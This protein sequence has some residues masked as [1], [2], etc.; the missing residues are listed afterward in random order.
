MLHVRYCTEKTWAQE[1]QGSQV[2]QLGFVENDKVTVNAY[3]S[4]QILG[5]F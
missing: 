1:T 3:A 5:I 4:Y 2:E